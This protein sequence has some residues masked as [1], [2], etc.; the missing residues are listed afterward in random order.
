MTRIQ[1]DL[2][3]APAWGGLLVIL[4]LAGGTTLAQPTTSRTSVG[5]LWTTRFT[6][7][8]HTLW[9]VQSLPDLSRVYRRGVTGAFKLLEPLGAPVVNL[10][11]TGDGLYAFV[12]DGAFY[13]L[14]AD[15][16][17][18]RLDLP[19]RQ[20][21]L[22]I[23]GDNGGVYVLIPSPAPG[24][25][26]RMVGGTRPATSQPFDA[27]GA[28]FSVARYD[29]R[30]WIAVAACP[31]TAKDNGSLTPRLSLIHDRLGLVWYA[32]SRQSIECVQFDSETDAW[33]NAG[34]V[35][36]TAVLSGFWITM[37]NRVP[38]IVL[39]SRAA[40]GSE[41]LSVF[42]LLGGSEGTD[43]RPAALRLSDLPQGVVPGP[44]Q[45]ALGFNQHVVLLMADAQ[46]KPLLRFGRIDANPTEVTLPVADVFERRQEPGQG[47]HWIQSA[48]VAAL[49]VVL[50]ALF[51]FRRSAMVT[52]LA[53]PADCAPA[54]TFQRLV[55]CAVDLAPFALAFAAIMGVDWRAAMRELVSWAPGG[56]QVP[57]ARTLAWWAVSCAAATVYSLVM[58]FLTQ[59]T[60][61][62]LMM[63]TRL[64][65]E[66]GTPAGVWPIVA[67]NAF[68]FLE[69]M[70]PFWLLG[71]LVVLSRNRQ[72]L[73]DIFARTL[74]VRRVR[75]IEET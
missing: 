38:A 27:G 58:E 23:L 57:S 52:V 14:G 48:T 64:L 11:A 63:G 56:D 29:S 47:P 72:R 28:A 60:V 18:C 40:D 69:L 33:R 55:G 50:V 66:N 12:A 39:A 10:A 2:R 45:A 74:V 36:V 24:Q 35:P 62:K 30:G 3:F 19:G 32:P 73:G 68:R 6:A 51:V 67:R 46:G 15:G 8:E 61:G 41:D 53:L 54:F 25:L 42:W 71:F 21:P 34:T 4:W 43:W 16:W 22:D 26:P 65:S 59:R 13:R 37:I 70:P 1:P 5:A 17:Q 9:L 49:F 20:Q 44:Y 7:E 75:R 31:T